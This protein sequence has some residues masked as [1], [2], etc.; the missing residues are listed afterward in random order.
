M[1]ILDWIWFAGLCVCD[2]DVACYLL[3]CLL[4]SSYCCVVWYLVS[5][6]ATL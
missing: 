6:L 4:C 2:F 5:L 1:I 3:G